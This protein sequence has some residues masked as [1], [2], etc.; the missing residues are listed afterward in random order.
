MW[1]TIA[2][3]PISTMIWPCMAIYITWRGGRSTVE[4]YGL[5]AFT[6]CATSI[7]VSDGVPECFGEDVFDDED[8]WSAIG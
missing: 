1:S 8:E 3:C 6:A 7:D 4:S 5:D 2:N